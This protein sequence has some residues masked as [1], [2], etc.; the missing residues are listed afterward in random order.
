MRKARPGG[1]SG[2]GPKA[3]DQ[4]SQDQ[5]NTSPVPPSNS[6][7][8]R[9]NRL[10]RFRRALDRWEEAGGQGPLPQASDFGLALPPLGSS[11]VLW[12]DGGRR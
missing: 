10:G 7:Q 1:A 9:L 12:C 5:D 2:N 8:D 4:S 6:P 11:E 3:L